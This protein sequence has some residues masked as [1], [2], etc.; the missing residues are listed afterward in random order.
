M[1]LWLLEY[2]D[3]S[4]DE[5]SA[6]IVR[7]ENESQARQLLA[8]EDRFAHDTTMALDDTKVTCVELFI[9]GEPGVIVTDVKEG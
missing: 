3:C 8:A 1:K 4:Y 7:A 9:D 5:L 2:A 6:A